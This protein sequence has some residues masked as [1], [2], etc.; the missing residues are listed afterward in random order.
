MRFTLPI[1]LV[2]L[3][4]AALPARAQQT[5]TLSGEIA[6]NTTLTSDKIWILQGFVYVRPP[7]TLTIEPGT[8]IRGDSATKGTLVIMRGAKINA[9][10]TAERPIVFTSNKAPGLRQQQ[11]WGGVVILGNATVNTP[12]DTSQGGL[13]TELGTAVI[14]GGLVPEANALYGGGTN[15][16]D[17][18]SSG[19]LRYVRIEFA[20]IPLSTA[21]NSEI[22]ALTLG[23]VGRRTV[24]DHVQIMFA[25]DDA[26]EFFGGTVNVS[27]LICGHT[28]DDDFDSDLGWTGNVQF[29][30]AFRNRNLWDQSTSNGFETDNDGQGTDNPPLTSGTFSNVTLIGPIRTPGGTLPVGN[31]FGRG[32]HVRRNSRIGVFNSLIV[33]FPEGLRLDGNKTVNSAFAGAGADFAFRNNVIAMCRKPF[34]VVS[35]TG[36]TAV[37]SAARYGW[38]TNAT[39]TNRVV[40]DV[41]TLGLVSPYTQLAPDFRPGASAPSYVL[42]GATWAHARL[43]NPFFTQV[44]YLG[45]FAPADTWL[46]G[47]TEFDPDLANYDQPLGVQNDLWAGAALAAAPNP[48]SPGGSLTLALTLPRAAELTLRVTDV[49]GRDVLT[50]PARSLPQGQSRW[51]L[52]ADALSQWNTG[53]YRVVL[54][55]AATGQVVGSVAVLVP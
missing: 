20:G 18:D 38:L 1:F 43:L 30:L 4:L 2:L 48:V 3:C 12:A 50:I 29:A 41:A 34:E 9:S 16:N 35:Y 25:G 24:I 32:L 28:Q 7:A 37:D 33:G 22:N 8:L 51:V 45:A 6:Q 14:E 19:V 46:D 17:D 54:S 11:Q 23:G 52:G 40:A 5:Q 10:G 15:P 42:T 21:A 31:R 47:W 26:I 55:E 36:S 39:N 13:V 27:H 53:L 49:L 44:A